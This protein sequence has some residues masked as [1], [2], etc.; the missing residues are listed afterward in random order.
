MERLLR[1]S[2]RLNLVCMDLE[3]INDNRDLSTLR[4]N[5]LYGTTPI[6]CY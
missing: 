6:V 4:V 3:H 5:R 1:S 2:G